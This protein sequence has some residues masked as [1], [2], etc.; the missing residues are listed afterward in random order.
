MKH[1]ILTTTLL[2][3]A[4][5]CAGI[6]N[7]GA[8]PCPTCP[9]VASVSLS[10]CEMDGGAATRS[11]FDG[12]RIE[13]KCSGYTVAVYSE[14]S[15]YDSRQVEGDCDEEIR[16]GIPA[17]EK[18]CVY[19]LANMWIMDPSGNPVS[20]V[21]APDTED[22][23][24][25]F[26]Y[27]LDGSEAPGGMRFERF[28]D[29][30]TLGIPAAGSMTVTK[31]TGQLKIDLSA[32]YLLSKLVLN[33]RHD[34]LTGISGDGTSSE[35]TNA[36]VFLRQVNSRL[37][38][39][40]PGGSRAAS[41][42]DILAESDF[43]AVMVSAADNRHEYVY[44][45]PE[46]MMGENP[47]LRNPGEKVP[48]NAPGGLGALVSYV[49]YTGLVDGGGFNGSLKCQFC[50]GANST[51]DFNVKRNTVY[52]VGVNFST[53]SIFSEPDW[54]SEP[55]I[56]D[57]RL[58][59]VSKDPSYSRVRLLDCDG[60]EDFIAVR[61]TRPGNCYLYLNNAGEYA[62]DN[63][64]AGRQMAPSA[65]FVPESLDDSRWWCDFS[66]LPEYGIDWSYSPSSGRICFSVADPS[67]FMRHLGERV[68]LRIDLL[69][70]GQSRDVVLALYPEQ[71]IRLDGL[72]YVATRN[73]AQ[74]SGFAAKTVSCYNSAP[75][76]LPALEYDGTGGRAYLPGPGDKAV[77]V[78][79]SGGGGAFRFIPCHRTDSDHSCIL[80]FV[81]DDPFNDD[82]IS[83]VCDFLAPTLSVS[84]AS[85]SLYV[86]GEGADA[87]IRYL[88]A[89]G[90]EIGYDEFDADAYREFLTPEYSFSGGI[91][92]EDG[93]CGFLPG[94]NGAGGYPYGEVCILRIPGGY[95][96]S[97]S[98]EVRL[99]AKSPGS[100]AVSRTFAIPAF[101]AGG[102]TGT[103]AT[104]EDYSL[105][106]PSLL[107]PSYR[108]C[109][110]LTV[111]DSG[112][113]FGVPDAS[114]VRFDVVPTSPESYRNDCLK[115]EMKAGAL[116][117]RI[118]DP[119]RENVRILHS[120]GRHK[121]TAWTANIHSGQ[122]IRSA[123]PFYVDVYCHAF[124]G[125]VAE[126][127]DYDSYRLEAQLYGMGMQNLEKISLWEVFDSGSISVCCDEVIPDQNYGSLRR[128]VEN[129]GTVSALRRL[130]EPGHDDPYLSVGFSVS[131]GDPE[132]LTRL[133]RLYSDKSGDEFYGSYEFF[134]SYPGLSIMDRNG[135]QS[136]KERDVPFGSLA[137]PSGHG[138]YVLHRL[139]DLCPSTRGW[140]NKY[141][142]WGML[143]YGGK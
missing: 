20:L 71:E 50:L 48:A 74:L 43:D 64:I 118:T 73:V 113:R 116:D 133:R 132:A 54:R 41:P 7:P 2:I 140:M 104:L 3:L 26:T 84:T 60:A 124:V 44:Y 130:P 108:P 117:I 49:E 127:V 21:E 78:T 17:A 123:Y 5:A 138:Y 128:K 98:Y 37:L 107:A 79:L 86:T 15:L 59:F 143:Y 120:A 38:P 100:A 19:V 65:S 32:E 137:D 4:C 6:E 101:Q 51:T 91:F 87:E 40:A 141:Y 16:I 67:A 70:G 99:T 81:P 95:D 103:L 61:L 62:S 88:D 92:G 18:F 125:A 27:R 97:R 56:D 25:E 66:V 58:F 119:E 30:G 76:S 55:D 83:A 122:R 28:S 36:S 24:M 129:H 105:V 53:G 9:G 115:V 114:D 121:V 82:P 23:M 72:G 93:C 96:S 68:R 69:P 111:T 77:P 139:E 131:G 29:I 94:G 14:G 33:I 11:I 8:S 45:L 42:G 90:N 135:K 46:N 89:D 52:N 63:D 110:Q 136:L 39:F 22:G 75:G 109:H 112:F 106:N 47:S 80:T 35:F 34:G 134:R 126:F 31:G 1:N 102:P 85:G 12:S 142:A 57:S 13:G 10:F